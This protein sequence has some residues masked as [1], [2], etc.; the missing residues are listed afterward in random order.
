MCWVIVVGAAGGRGVA[1]NLF[2]FVANNTNPPTTLAKHKFPAYNMSKGGSE[3]NSFV[4]NCGL[5]CVVILGRGLVG[6]TLYGPHGNH[7]LP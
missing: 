3:H 2:A 4:I 7:Q 1:H 6:R 5:F